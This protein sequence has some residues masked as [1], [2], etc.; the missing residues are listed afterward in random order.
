MTA[1]MAFCA[2]AGLAAVGIAFYERRPLSLILGI[3]AGMVFGAAVLRGLREI[4]KATREICADLQKDSL[5][6]K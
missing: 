2:L 6:K 4:F 3:L 1:A 5:E